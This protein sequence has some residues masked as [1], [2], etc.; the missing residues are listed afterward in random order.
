MSGGG[1]KATLEGE[2]MGSAW[3][4]FARTGNPHAEGSPEREPYTP[5]NGARQRTAGY[6]T[7]VS[8]AG[9]LGRIKA[10]NYLINKRK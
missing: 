6:C 8:G 4:D 3:I 1:H 7:V 9:F 5:E 2:K 10:T